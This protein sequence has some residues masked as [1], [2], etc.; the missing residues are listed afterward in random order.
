MQAA[1]VEQAEHRGHRAED[2]YRRTHIR[3][4]VEFVIPCDEA[5]E[6]IVA[7]KH[8]R[9]QLLAGREQQVDDHRDRIGTYDEVHHFPER[10]NV[11]EE[12]VR[13]RADHEHEP[14]QVWDEEPL[15][16]RYRIVERAV[17]DIV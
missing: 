1:A 12:G 2:V 6:R 7:W 13:Q 16:E 10:R 17:H 15:A 5:R 14:E 8:L 4:S 9:P 3:V 11:A